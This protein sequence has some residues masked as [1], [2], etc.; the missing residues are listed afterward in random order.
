L[1]ALRQRVDLDRGRSDCRPQEELAMTTPSDIKSF[2]QALPILERHGMTPVKSSEP[3]LWAIGART[4]D[5]GGVI[6]LAREL[7][8]TDA[9]ATP[10][11]ALATR[12]AAIDA[13][14]MMDQAEARETLQMMRGDLEQIDASLG[15]FRQRALDFR[16]RE[17]W[18]ALGYAGYL[19]A[20]NSELG[21]EYSKSYLSRILKAAEIERLLEL[22][23]GNPI[24][25]R[26]L[27]PLGQLDDPDA[28]RA[29]WQ[30]A[31][32]AAE[33][34]T[35]TTA[36]VEAAV[37]FEDARRRFAVLGWKFERHGAW[38]KLSKPNGDHY[39]TLPDLRPHLDTLRVFEAN[40]TRQAQE[41]ARA[42]SDPESAIADFPADF[43]A[44]QHR[45]E[46]LGAR[47]FWQEKGG[48]PWYTATW[49]GQA[50]D[51]TT[52][53][54]SNVI[55]RLV[56]QERK[57]ADQ[58]QQ[59]DATVGHASDVTTHPDYRAL[60]ARLRPHGW[61]IQAAYGHAGS[62]WL[63]RVDKQQGP[64][65]LRD[66]AAVHAFADQLDGIVVE[67]PLPSAPIT[68]ESRD[69]DGPWF[70][71][72]KSA[73][74]PTAHHW[75]VRQST[76]GHYVS[77][78]GIEVTAL[79]TANPDAGLCSVCAKHADRREI[80]P[81]PLSP[82]ETCGKQAAGKAN[83]GGHLAWRCEPCAALAES[84]DLHAQLGQQYRGSVERPELGPGPWHRIYWA[85]GGGGDYT[86]VQ[87]L[88]QL[89]TRSRPALPPAPLRALCEA[90]ERHTAPAQE[91]T[92][93]VDWDRIRRCA[94]VLRETTNEVEAL[95]H[96]RCIVA[97]LSKRD[98]RAY[99]A[100]LLRMLAP[101]M[102]DLRSENLED[103]SQAIADLNECEKCTEG[104][105]W[106]RVGWALLDM[107][108]PERAGV[109]TLESEGI[110][111]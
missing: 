20:I 16:E 4:L 90:W 42:P 67:S 66:W 6:A 2:S 77:A 52:P 43:A 17:G 47:L 8:A 60:V 74:H 29:A 10:S 73:A 31:S 23:A 58:E 11:A 24:P 104:E 93:G 32:E 81:I 30:A 95:E 37:T 85:G 94:Y 107:E 61:Y 89:A 80:V 21:T 15:S 45:Y 7:A 72:A 19:E 1:Y 54:W 69:A 3:K 68:P 9:S 51:I 99:A 64:R 39:V 110:T 65:N 76:Q 62:L 102:A 87:A 49:P 36:A 44:I 96:C 46:A 13:V 84:E 97:A 25:E 35:P 63:V 48:V 5:K 59:R 79:P 101:L 108:P 75:N 34:D 105:H 83:I 53:T 78:C 27:R 111:A 82:C 86:Y 18:K 28:Q 26:T 40:A 70:K 106:A 57:A 22:P 55:D 14:V 103:L 50:M 92:S 41:L 12:P 71:A 109:Q 88:D 33:G 56:A 98:R 91:A 38:Y 100:Q